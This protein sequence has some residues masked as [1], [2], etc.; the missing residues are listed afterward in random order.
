MRRPCSSGARRRRSSARRSGRPW[1][2]RRSRRTGA[3]R[4][5]CRRRWCGPW[6][7]VA[8]DRLGRA[9]LDAGVAADLLVAAVGADLLLVV[10]ELR[11]LELADAL[12]QLEHRVEQRR[13]RRRRG[14]SPA[15]AGAGRSAAR[16]R[17]RARGRSVSVTAC[18]SRCEVDRAGG[19]ADAHAVAVAGALREVDL[20]AEVDRLLRADGD[21]GIAARAQVEVDRVGAGPARPRTRRASR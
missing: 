9:D 5:R 7:G 6:R 18:G 11:L 2:R 1:C 21:A 14:S 17:G 12:A 16:R 15:A 19:L 3:A 10:E 20:V 8:A 13:R 4:R